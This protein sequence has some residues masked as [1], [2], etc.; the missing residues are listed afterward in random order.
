MV[1]CSSASAITF[2]SS[3]RSAG[4]LANEEASLKL[5][6][7]LMLALSALCTAPTVFQTQ[8]KKYQTIQ[9]AFH[10]SNLQVKDLYAPR[11]SER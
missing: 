9:A 11:D 8:L 5:F 2:L 7:V 4:F 10:L 1:G 6:G 3:S